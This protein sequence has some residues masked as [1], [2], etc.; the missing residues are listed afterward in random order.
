MRTPALFLLSLLVACNGN[1]PTADTSAPPN[2]TGDPVETGT[3]DDTGTPVLPKDIDGDGYTDDEDCDDAN[4]AI[5]PG[6]DEY[7]NDVDNDCDGVRDNDPVD[8]RTWYIDADGDG[9]GDSADGL[10]SCD[11][12]EDRVS[13]GG[14]CD[15][16]DDGV[17]P[18]ALETCNGVDDNCDGDT[19]GVG[20]VDAA[21]WY[22]DADADGF[23]DP[24]APSGGC[25]APTGTVANATDCNDSDAT[26]NPNALESCDGTDNNCDGNVDE[27][28]ATD[29]S[30]FYA[31]ADGDGFG[32]AAST[33]S[34]CSLPSGYTTS[35]NDCD[36]ADANAYPGA[37]EYCNGA[38]DD[39]DSV[40]DENDAI[41]VATWYADIDGDGHGDIN[42][43]SLSCTQPSNTS[44]VPT[45]CDDADAEAYLGN[46]EVCDDKDN[47][48]DGSTDEGV[49]TTYYADADADTYGDSSQSVEAC[50]QPTGHAGNGDD[51]DDNAI[52]VNPGETEICNGVDDNCDGSTDEGVLTTFYV[53]SDTDGYGDAANPTEDCALPSGYAGTD[54]DCDDDAIAVNPGATE[55][56]D[57]IDNDCDGTVDE[58]DAADAQTYYADA[59]GDGY[60]DLYSPVVAC[61]VPTGH[62]SNSTDCLDWD[63]SV[64]AGAAELCDGQVNNCGGTIPSDEVD[65]DSDGYVE[66]TVDGGGWDGVGAFSGGDDCDDGATG[67]NPGATENCDGI[68]NNCDGTI[69]EDSAAN[70]ST[71]YAD[72]DGDGFGDDNDSGTTACTAPGLAYVASDA[73]D[74]DDGNI[75]VNTSVAEICDLIDNNCDGNADENLVPTDMVV[76]LAL[77]A[78]AVDSSGNGHN[79]TETNI[80]AA[81]DR[82]GN[83]NGA[84][85]FN[86]SANITIPDHADL[87]GFTSFTICSWLKPTFD[88]AFDTHVA[89]SKELQGDNSPATDSY[90]TTLNTGAGGSTAG[91]LGAT[92]STDTG[93][94]V[95]VTSN[96]L[97]QNTWSHLCIVYDGSSQD[98]FVDGVLETTNAA[99][100]TVNDTTVEITLGTCVATDNT[101]DDRGFVGA[102]DD[103]RLFN[104]DLTT[105]EVSCLSIQ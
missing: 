37:S 12:I 78:G 31:D 44:S 103:W 88:A 8:P 64:F 82:D 47:N 42:S 75:N 41:D 85:W 84:T 102:L 40:V 83:N 43:P 91:Q 28:E 73:T 25:D 90:V 4:P 6:A 57:G 22:A 79:G 60:G 54:D 104:R 2:D 9:F 15:D 92:V 68:D 51:C 33:L 67:V 61:A 87:D 18:D 93:A 39:C 1:K 17:H 21:T 23:G 20:A 48:C 53:D 70:A 95:S 11:P 86:G 96:P 62:V 46:A 77:N 13:T 38:D 101:C 80:S 66:C 49:T 45:D 10:D 65:D 30:T 99:S 29:G 56:C 98:V 100:G 32:D 35:S 5:Y 26:V 94:Y 24:N 36:D 27:G 76:H 69:D 74:C 14:D 16:A 81:A 105:D 52:A 63:D 50:A 72:V 34:A 55:T 71:W 7:C 89:W 3:E 97:P 58:N 19:D 59:D